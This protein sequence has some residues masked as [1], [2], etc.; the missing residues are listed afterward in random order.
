MNGIDM[1]DRYNSLSLI[2]SG[3]LANS[4][5][6][7]H[8][9]KGESGELGQDEEKLVDK[10]ILIEKALYRKVGPDT[11]SEEFPF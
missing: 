1:H 10:A 7:K 8:T 5:R 9:V 6:Y 3:L 11:E 4:K 2:I